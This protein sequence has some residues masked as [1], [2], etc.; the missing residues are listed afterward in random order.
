MHV[1]PLLSIHERHVLNRQRHMAEFAVDEKVLGFLD[2]I[3]KLHGGIVA[4]A[5]SLDNLVDDDF[6]RRRTRRQADCRDIGKIIPVDFR[7]PLDKHRFF[8]AR[9]ERNFNQAL[10][11]DEF[12]APTMMKWSQPGAAC[13]TAS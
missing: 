12:G 8:C 1:L 4:F 9:P 2:C 10:E 6:R 11:F 7:R 13:F 5:K 3:G